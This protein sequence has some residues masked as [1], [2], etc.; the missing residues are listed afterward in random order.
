MPVTRVEI[1][2]TRE[3]MVAVLRA[4]HPELLTDTVES[5]TLGMLLYD[6]KGKLLKS[7]VI[8]ADN[9]MLL[10]D[11]TINNEYERQARRKAFGAVLDS[12]AIVVNGTYTLFGRKAVA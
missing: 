8:T 11:G 9:D 5:S 7:A 12:G 3:Q 1:T 10:A 6:S 4:R 2:P